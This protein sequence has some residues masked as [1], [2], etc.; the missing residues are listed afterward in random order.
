LSGC[1]TPLALARHGIPRK[2]YSLNDQ[3]LLDASLHN[4][5]KVHLGFL[6]AR[7]RSLNTSRLMANGA[8]H[9]RGIVARLTGFDVSEALSTPFLYGLHRESIVSQAEFAGH[10][11]ACEKMFSTSNYGDP[12]YGGYV[13]GNVKIGSELLAPEVWGDD[14]SPEVFSA[15]FRTTEYG[16]DPVVLCQEVSRAVRSNPLIELNTNAHIE[17]IHSQPGG[18]FAFF[19]A[20]GSRIGPPKIDC[21][22]NCSWADLLRLD[23]QV[24]IPSPP[25]WSYRYKLGS[26]MARAIL[27][28][29]LD[30]VTAVLGPFGDIVNYGKTGSVFLSWYPTGLLQFTDEVH[31]PDWNGPG[32]ETERRE[33]YEL[34]RSAWQEMSKKLLALDLEQAEFNPKGG[35]ILATGRIDVGDPTSPLHSR[36]H[37]GVSQK[38]SYFSLNPG[39][40]TLAPLMACQTANKIEEH[41]SKA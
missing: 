25:D 12:S 29:Q 28:E 35:V 37:V 36:V 15:V 4:E 13:D 1:W 10:L 27:P 6:Y 22:I 11:N 9:F 40:Y 18:S 39:K 26:R 38:G 5:G 30:S 23:G 32:F 7:D 2:I 3:E 41:F 20:E 21:V 31:L 8:R 14:L 17:D 33:A 19:D 34:S 24:A 16:V